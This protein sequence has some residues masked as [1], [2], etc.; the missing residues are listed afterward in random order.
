MNE[1]TSS[2][3]AGFFLFQGSHFVRTENQE[4]KL[5]LQEEFEASILPSVLRDEDRISL[6]EKVM[7]DRITEEDFRAI[8]RPL[9][10]SAISSLIQME[11]CDRAITLAKDLVN[12]SD[13]HVVCSQLLDQRKYEYVLRLLPDLN[14]S[15]QSF[16]LHQLIDLGLEE[17]DP[18]ICLVTREIG[19]DTCSAYV[20]ERFI[21]AGKER[22]ALLIAQLIENEDHRL[23]LVQHFI[24]EEMF[25]SAL[26]LALA[27]VT[28]N[29]R[30]RMV[31]MF[32]AAERSDLANIL[33]EQLRAQVHYI[34]D[35][36]NDRI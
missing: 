21:M 33:V 36:E 16:S 6:E 35:S 7:N 30:W 24:D 20:A 8:L 22:E 26:S 3:P 25:T 34:S 4:T 10:L 15:S 5:R 32:R 23:E 19:D 18:R 17:L 27:T 14:P 31:E 1:L 11:E 12:R 29:S 13:E 2:A 9:R 28:T